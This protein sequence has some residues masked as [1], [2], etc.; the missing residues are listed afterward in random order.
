ML[1]WSKKGCA[2]ARGNALSGR[3]VKQAEPVNYPRGSTQSAA[4]RSALHRPQA[5]FPLALGTVAGTQHVPATLRR[6]FRWVINAS[7]VNSKHW[8]ARRTP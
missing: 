5:R 2:G 4:T 7:C 1:R 6:C 3:P 8:Y